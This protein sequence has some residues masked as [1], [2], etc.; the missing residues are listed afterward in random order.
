[1]TETPSAR[2][3]SSQLWFGRQGCVL[4]HGS[5]FKLLTSIHQEVEDKLKAFVLQ[6]YGFAKIPCQ[7]STPEVEYDAH[8]YSDSDMGF[9]I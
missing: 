3:I 7:E 6:Y 9:S 8:K 4:H 5:G 1:M 2:E